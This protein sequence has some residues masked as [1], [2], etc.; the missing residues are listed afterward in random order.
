[1]SRFLYAD[2][3][4][5]DCRNIQYGIA[6]GGD[7]RGDA[8]GKAVRSAPVVKLGEQG[9]RGTA[10]YRARQHEREYIRRYAE[11]HRKRGDEPRGKIEKARRGEHRH[12]HEQGDE[13][14]QQLYAGDNTLVCAEQKIIEA[15]FL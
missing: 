6:R 5:I 15:R 11:P 10:G 2:G 14:R 9:T 3:T 4:E 7:D 13:G 12:R 1:M 8:R